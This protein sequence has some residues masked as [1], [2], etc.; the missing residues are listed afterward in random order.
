[1]V[2]RVQELIHKLEEGEGVFWV[3]RLLMVLGLLG[4]LAWYDLREFKNMSAPDAMDAAQ[5]ARNVSEGKGFVTDCV[6][7]L[8]MYLVAK[9]RK[10]GSGLLKNGHPDLSNPPVYPVL[11]AG[12]MKVL[13]FQWDIP[14]SIQ[15][16]RYQPDL[17]VAFFNQICF[18]AASIILFFLARKLFDAPAAL[19]ATGVFIG[20]DLYWKFSVSGLST[21]FVIVLFLLLAW[22]L[23]ILEE[24]TRQEQPKSIKWFFGWAVAAGLLLGL[25]MLTRYGY[26][27]LLLPVVLY[28]VLFMGQRRGVVLAAT[29][30]SFLLVVT[31]WCIRNYQLS[32]TLFGTAGY[33]VYQDTLIC[34]G[35]MIERS[36]VPNEALLKTFGFDD[37]IKKLLSN[38]NTILQNDL[39]VMSGSW[40]SAFFLASLLISFQSIAISRM[41]VF[42]VGSI[43]TMIIVQALGKTH[44][45]EASAVIN[46]EN[47]L[48]LV[49]PLVLPFGAAMV[50]TLLEQINFPEP[51][52]K[53]WISIGIWVVLCLPLMITLLPPKANALSYPPYYPWLT[54]KV[55]HFMKPDETIMSDI[56]WA[57]AWHGKRQ[58]IW[59]AMNAINDFNLINDQKSVK[60]I[61]ITQVTMD[62][63]LTST[64]VKGPDRAWGRFIIDALI[65]NELPKNFPLQHAWSDPL[66][67]QFLLS[68]WERWRKV[69]E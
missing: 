53:K 47:Y 40:L 62:A 39:P 50:L 45:S 46:S 8:S 19:L 2:P 64:L 69:G 66:P 26:G 56:P 41:R 12:W 4:V 1:M 51:I 42:V 63:R 10:D 49:G 24:G 28:L 3:K 11:L 33:A 17:L 23:V 20:S 43:F 14:E 48:A 31:P 68:D 15:F 6:R 65:K 35:N 44:L 58:S 57:V 37:I 9:E 25:G 13:P 59:L 22:V 61:Y 67:D 52:F 5:L 27:W 34:P 32:G 36:L 29:I 16:N 54:Q 38:G 60:A 18:F 7:P 30:L 21:M 55:A